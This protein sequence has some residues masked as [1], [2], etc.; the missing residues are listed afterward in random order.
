MD[1]FPYYITKLMA[2][3]FKRIEEV[4]V[5]NEPRPGLTLI[6]G[7]NG[8]G[9]TSIIDAVKA[10]L[11]G[12]RGHPDCP[13]RTGAQE[14]SIELELQ[15]VQLAESLTVTQTW[16][17]G[18]GG[19]ASELLVQRYVD[20]TPRRVSKPQSA[21]N[22]IVGALAFDPL[23]LIAE[24]DTKK[25]AHMLLDAA[26]MGEQFDDRL[27][28]IEAYEAERRTAKALRDRVQ[29]QVTALPV[30]SN[31]ET[32]ERVNVAELLDEVKTIGEQIRIRQ[33]AEEGVSVAAN[34]V[35]LAKEGLER[36]RRL[37]QTTIEDLVRLTSPSVKESTKRQQAIE[38][39]LATA[40]AQNTLVGQQEHRHDLAV[41]LKIQKEN[42]Q[43]V[44]NKLSF[45]RDRLKTIVTE[46]SIVDGLT[47][48]EDRQMFFNGI[49]FKQT[50]GRDQLLVSTRVAMRMNQRLRVMCIDEGDRLDPDSLVALQEIA[51]QEGYQV[52]MTAVYADAPNSTVV[53][54]A[55]GH[56][57]ETSE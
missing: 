3:D 46:A 38:A 17:R 8:A 20:G 25:Q 14:A 13:I 29:Q 35:E 23:A 53:E 28:E 37:L 31:E 57:V 32:G 40:E 2:R 7:P 39:T 21:L 11:T 19:V 15:D 34:A 44:D 49:P 51:E 48:D 5:I 43:A 50:A 4:V 16:K 12:K 52:W 1:N 41:D 10:A 56:I 6:R 27:A 36:S 33:R 26:G 54:V 18:P 45:A 30:T 22:E 9:K 24:K 55:D 47:V 42:V